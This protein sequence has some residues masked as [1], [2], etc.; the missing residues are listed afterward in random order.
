M[1]ERFPGDGERSQ[2]VGMPWTGTAAVTELVTVGISNG[3]RFLGRPADSAEARIGRD[4]VWKLE[5]AQPE[6]D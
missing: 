6:E 5:S 1:T 2:S 3:S 4:W